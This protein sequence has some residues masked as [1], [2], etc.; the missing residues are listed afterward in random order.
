MPIT[1]VTY[2]VMVLHVV[3]SGNPD[4]HM[5]ERAVQLLQVLHRYCVVKWSCVGHRSLSCRILV[6]I[7][8]GDVSSIVTPGCST[9]RPFS[10][11]ELGVHKET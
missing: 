8:C 4:H 1:P 6:V 5:R 10:M 11:V 3:L 9:A 7:C 2:I